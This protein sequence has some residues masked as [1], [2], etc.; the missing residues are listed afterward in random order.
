MSRWRLQGLE[1]ELVIGRVHLGLS[2]ADVRHRDSRAGVVQ[3]LANLLDG[4]PAVVHQPPASFP[5]RVSAELQAHFLA[6]GLEGVCY[7]DAAYGLTLGPVAVYLEQVRVRGVSSPTTPHDGLYRAVQV[8]GAGLAGL[9]FLDHQLIALNIFEG[10][11]EKV[12]DAKGGV[13]PEPPDVCV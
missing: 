13:D 3:Y 4:H 12:A 1:H 9:A 11:A 6:Y 2:D 5:H 7:R 10:E 8:N